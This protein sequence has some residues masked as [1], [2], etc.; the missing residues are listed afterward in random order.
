MNL[1]SHKQK[2]VIRKDVFS[3]LLFVFLGIVFLSAM[4]FL[5][6]AYNS[7]LYL[8]L[9]I[10][11]IEERLRIEQETQKANIVMEVES[12]I[13]DLNDILLTIDKIRKK[14]SFN[15]P[16]IL[17]VLGRMAPEGVVFRT[18]TFRGENIGIQ[19][20]AEGR[21]GVLALKKNLEEEPLFTNIFSPL[22]NIVKE[23]D[24]NFTFN[25]AIDEK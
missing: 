11:A 12:D 8:E 9:Q 13:E 6:L 1:L 19:G 3:R 17:R 20:H 22:S 25:F 4:V 21:A 5:V 24:I 2:D 16:Y 7:V 14:E 10:P 23:R 18:I 15:F